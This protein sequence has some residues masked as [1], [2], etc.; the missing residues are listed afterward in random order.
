MLLKEI[1]ILLINLFL[2]IFQ[3]Q[4]KNGFG[5]ILPMNLLKL[6]DISLKTKRLKKLVKVLL[7]PK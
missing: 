6:K 2:M 1:M 5:E 4:K 3:F 7:T